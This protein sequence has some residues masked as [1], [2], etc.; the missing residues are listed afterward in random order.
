MTQPIPPDFV[1]P[2]IHAAVPAARL[3][4]VRPHAGVLPGVVPGS[5]PAAPVSHPLAVPAPAAPL[6]HPPLAVTGWPGA[7]RPH[8]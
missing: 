7:N 6:S 2:E 5:V 3:R 1:A 4:A 8:P